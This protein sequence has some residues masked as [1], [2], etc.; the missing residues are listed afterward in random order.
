M[1]N[2]LNLTKLVFPSSLVPQGI[3][4][5]IEMPNLKVTTTITEDL[6]INIGANSPIKTLNFGTFII[7]ASQLNILLSFFK[8]VEGNKSVFWLKDPFDNKASKFPNV[9]FNSFS[10]G[11]AI[12]H[13]T[14]LDRA[15]LFKLY[16]IQTARGYKGFLRRIY[17]IENVALISANNYTALPMSIES[18]GSVNDESSYSITNISNT[19]TR[20]NHNR[21]VNLSFLTSIAEFNF[22]T[23]FRFINDFSYTPLS[24]NTKQRIYQISGLSMQEVILPMHNNIK[25]GFY[26]YASNNYINSAPS[27]RC[28]FSPTAVIHRED[29]VDYNFL[30]NTFNFLY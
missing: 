8:Q 18:N 4:E 5:S 20:Y 29:T 19:V 6:Y 10:Q 9:N 27:S 23:P 21:S 30:F 16:A 3:S 15:D 13:P 17:R 25:A 14:Q 2:R 11:L 26:A 24:T 22:L 28:A 12:Y 1:L 7:N